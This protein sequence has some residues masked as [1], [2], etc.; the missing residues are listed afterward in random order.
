MVTLYC[1][2]QPIDKREKNTFSSTNCPCGTLGANIGYVL[3]LLVHG[4]VLVEFGRKVFLV[5]YG[6]IN[7]IAKISTTERA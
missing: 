6:E 1:T 4:K 3:G 2:H 5:D 7:I